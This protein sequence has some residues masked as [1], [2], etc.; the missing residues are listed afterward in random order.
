I[1]LAIGKNPALSLFKEINSKGGE[2]D[3]EVPDYPFVTD[4]P[5]FLFFCRRRLQTTGREKARPGTRKGARGC[6]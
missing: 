5:G 4:S 1:R 3:E 2:R 6:S